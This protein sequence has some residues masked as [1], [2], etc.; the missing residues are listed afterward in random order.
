MVADSRFRHQGSR[1]HPPSEVR[2]F[3]ASF[4][5]T[6]RE[7]L[8][9]SVTSSATVQDILHRTVAELCDTVLSA[10]LRNRSSIS[11]R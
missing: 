2:S 8:A 5:A 6:V 10:W 3:N 4:G 1:R 7:P 9:R 11:A